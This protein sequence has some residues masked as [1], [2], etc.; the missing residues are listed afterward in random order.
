[1]VPY[2]ILA[3][4]IGL[5]LVAL[6]G[7]RRLAG[8]DGART[9]AERLGGG[10]PVA[11]GA[12]WLHGASVGELVSA[13]PLIAALAPGG[14][15]VTANTETGRAR[16][17][18]WGIPGVAARMAPVD[19]APVLRRFLVRHRPRALVLVE[20]DLW[21]GRILTAMARGLPVMLVSARISERSA[22]RWAR[23]PGLARGILGRVD[24]VAPQDAGAAKRLRSLGVPA[25]R[26]GPVLNLKAAGAMA[27]AA[28]AGGM[29][30]LPG[31]PRTDTVLAASTHAG[32]DAPVLDGFIAA[33]ESRPDLRLIL[34]PRHPDR[35][36]E[37]ARL[38]T[39][40]GLDFARRSLGE[41]P[42][43]N[44]PVYLA[45]TLGEM[46][47]WYAAAG[48][49]FVGGSL[50]AKGGHTP[51]EPEAQG[52]AILHGP[53]TANFTAA[54]AALAGDGGAVKVADA[55]E[56]AAA[57]GALADAGAQAAMA[58]RAT[59][60]LAPLRAGVDLAPVLERLQRL[61]PKG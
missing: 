11:R 15:L 43:A 19:W 26:I 61:A 59:A 56:L 31:F 13:R 22:A 18:A 60:A 57:I 28:L 25:D 50:V 44:R 54:Y 7:L 52:S 24:W 27:G 9:L 4:L 58:A 53:D 1:V 16:V 35:G 51:F 10:A 33:R 34:A 21:P 32:E 39:A 55:A 3:P 8:R 23:V 49:T 42:D 36:D 2:R 48:V 17:E 46:A 14:V 30:P 37:V 5:L 40:K 6:A 47:L 41:A 20:G 45:D 12:V 29:G 38:I